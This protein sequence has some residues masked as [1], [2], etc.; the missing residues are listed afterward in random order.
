MCP[1]RDSN[2]HVLRH[3][4]LRPTRLPLRHRGLYHIRQAF[5]FPQAR[6]CILFNP[7]LAVWVPEDMIF[8][9]P[10]WNRTTNISLEV[11]S[12]IHL[13]NRPI[14]N[15]TSYFLRLFDQLNGSVQCHSLQAW[16][17]VTRYFSMMMHGA[18]WLIVKA[19]VPQK[20][21]EPLRTMSTKF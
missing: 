2:S 11:R 13:T 21:L 20:G 15:L 1:K 19:I 17:A 8:C 6:N 5:Y 12:Y 10:S 9:S 16:R 3:W 18:D 7:T 4:F 14:N